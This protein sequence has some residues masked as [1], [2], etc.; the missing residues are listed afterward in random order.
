MQPGL[1]PIVTKDG[2]VYLA[3]S[4]SQLGRDF[5]ETSVPATGLGGFGP[6]PGEP[7]VAPARILRFERVGDQVVMRWP[8]TFARVVPRSPQQVSTTQ[9]VSSLSHRDLTDRGTR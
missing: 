7:Y 6:A 1:I 9:S 4:T 2:K 5:I 8:N 3:L